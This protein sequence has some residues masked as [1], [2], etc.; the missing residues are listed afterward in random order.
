[1]PTTVSREM[2]DEGFN[3]NLYFWDVISMINDGTY[4]DLQ[5]TAQKGIRLDTRDEKAHVI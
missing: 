4:N 3:S 1:M 2:C 5:Y